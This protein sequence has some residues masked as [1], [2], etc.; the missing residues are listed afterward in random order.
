MIRQVLLPT[1]GTVLLVASF[2]NCLGEGGFTPRVLVT[3]PVAIAGLVLV[4][5]RHWAKD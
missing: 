5:Q 3:I 4:A 1:I 2:F